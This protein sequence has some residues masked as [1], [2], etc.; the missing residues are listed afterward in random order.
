MAPRLIPDDQIENFRSA[1]MNRAHPIPLLTDLMLQ[2]GLRIAETLA[3]TWDD[4]IFNR[5]P[6]PH[7]RLCHHTT[8]NNRERILPINKN[9]ASAIARAWLIQ[10]T[11]APWLPRTWIAATQTI[12]PPITP[13]TVQRIIRDIGRTA[14]GIHLT[15]HMLRHTFATRLL[16]VADI[17]TVQ[18]ALGHARVSTTQIYTHPNLN[19][20]TTAIQRMDE[21]T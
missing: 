14:L 18:E 11:E 13:R 3:L 20:L 1:A 2:A 19:D 8:K 7:L 10:P 15:P 16:R 4:L 21:K 5:H 12:G 17:R 9:L 6:K